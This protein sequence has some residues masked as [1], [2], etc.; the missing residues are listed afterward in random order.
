M[1]PYKEEQHIYKDALDLKHPESN[2]TATEHNLKQTAINMTFDTVEDVA[3]FTSA[4]FKGDKEKV[5]KNE[6]NFIN[7]RKS[8][9]LFIDY[10]E[11]C[12]VM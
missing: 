6:P 2:P 12:V 8:D 9:D 5:Y 1:F 7:P 4:V 10:S 11:K 3:G